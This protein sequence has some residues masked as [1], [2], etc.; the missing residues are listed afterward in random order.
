MMTTLLVFMFF[1]F[2]SLAASN[3]TPGLRD[4]LMFEVELPDG[5]FA[6]IGTPSGGRISLR[7]TDQ[8]V[9][10]VLTATLEGEAV[11]L[12]VLEVNDFATG[13]AAIIE[14]TRLHLRLG[15]SAQISGGDT[16]FRVEWVGFTPRDA[17]TGDA[18]AGPCTRCCVY[19]GD[20][21]W[22]GCRVETSC[23]GCCCPAACSCDGGTNAVRR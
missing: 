15:E 9:R 21:E 7:P 2:P 8:A 17:T 12:V 6:R 20:Q 11:E 18:Q 4:T 22:C 10:H 19:C 1:V 5:T 14:R 23:G 16:Q 3:Q 13:E